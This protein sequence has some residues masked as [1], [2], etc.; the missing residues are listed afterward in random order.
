MGR[1]PWPETQ[2]GIYIVI[3]ETDKTIQTE[4]VVVY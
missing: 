1:Q 3:L 4:K 2:P